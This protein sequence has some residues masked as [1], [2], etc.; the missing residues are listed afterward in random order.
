MSQRRTVP[1]RVAQFCRVN[2]AHAD[3]CSDLSCRYLSGRVI[4]SVI[5]MSGIDLAWVIGDGSGLYVAN[6]RR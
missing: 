5:G 1:G 2:I 6:H 4:R 3:V